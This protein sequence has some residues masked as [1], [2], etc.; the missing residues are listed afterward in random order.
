[1]H[2]NPPFD[3]FQLMIDWGWEFM[4]STGLVDKNGRDIFEGDIIVHPRSKNP[5]SFHPNWTLVAC[6]VIWE[7]DKDLSP[8]KDPSFAQEEPCFT[9]IPL[10]RKSKEAAWGYNWSPFHEC[11]IVGNIYE[12]P[13]ML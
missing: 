7:D 11:E 5:D 13:E 4:Q 2:H 12:N 6:Q 1:M 10:D 3:Q 9:A 8:D